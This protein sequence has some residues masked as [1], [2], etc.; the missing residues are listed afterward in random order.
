MS[1]IICHYDSTVGFSISYKAHKT[2]CDYAIKSLSVGGTVN[3]DNKLTALPNRVSHNSPVSED[4]RGTRSLKP[5]GVAC[6]RVCFRG[7]TGLGGARACRRNRLFGPSTSTYFTEGLTDITDTGALAG[8]EGLSASC[9]CSGTSIENAA[10]SQ[11][12]AKHMAMLMHICRPG[13]NPNQQV[14][15]TA[16][17]LR[18]RLQKL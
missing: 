6:V 7:S 12:S 8:D 9:S 17:L 13:R 1:Q 15:A 2:V 18:Q 5:A 11:F 10:M 3:V 14:E 4:S 16:R